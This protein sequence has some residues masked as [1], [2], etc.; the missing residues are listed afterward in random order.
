MH[1]NRHS[2][3]VQCTDDSDAS[4]LMCTA[5]TK[6]NTKQMWGVQGN[7]L[8]GLYTKGDESW[9]KPM[10]LMAQELCVDTQSVR[11][12]RGTH[13]EYSVNM[14]EHTWIHDTQSEKREN[15]IETPADKNPNWASF[16]NWTKACNLKGNDG[17]HSRGRNHSGSLCL[18]G[19]VQ[20]LTKY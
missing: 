5:N 20:V 14:W 12:I 15:T 6:T 13:T 19:G 10:R 1:T 7:V 2:P 11:I 16:G 9:R 4:G 17:L 8:K 3:R 18:L